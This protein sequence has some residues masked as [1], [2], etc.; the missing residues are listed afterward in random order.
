MT[1]S[2][3]PDLGRRIREERQARGMGLRELARAVGVSASMVSQIEN[4]RSRP[5]VSTLYAITTALRI[6][7][8]EVFAPAA[9]AVDPAA[10]PVPERE[11]RA[12]GTRSG[13][14]LGPVVTPPARAR[15]TL[16]TGVCWERLGEIPGRPVDFLA[17][18]YPP[19]ATSSRSGRLMQHPGAEFGTVVSGELILTLGPEEFVLHAGDAVSFESAVPHRYR[20]DG[21][22][23]AVGTWFVVERP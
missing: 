16:E 13:I 22:V 19:G 8:D 6:S 4:G 7:I 9:T 21:A 23:P 11:D 12:L 15:L 1:T 10:Q 2:D 5:S 14:R 20:N 18:T 3:V 17:I